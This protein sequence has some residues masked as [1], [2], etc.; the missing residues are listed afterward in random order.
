MLRFDGTR[1]LSYPAG[2]PSCSLRGVHGTGP[3]D[4]WAV[5][6]QGIAWHFNGSSWE[7]DGVETKYDL[8]AVW[9]DPTGV[10]RAAGHGTDPGDDAGRQRHG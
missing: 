8:N 10:A 4:V 9:V 7:A 2:G 3:D 6:G 5:G 1:W